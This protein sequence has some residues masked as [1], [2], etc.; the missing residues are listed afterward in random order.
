[1]R[2][3][4]GIPH[5]LPPTLI[6]DRHPP[7][8]PKRGGHPPLF[9]SRGTGASHGL[10]TERSFSGLL[11]GRGYHPSCARR[12]TH[13]LPRSFFGA[14]NPL[15]PCL[16]TGRVGTPPFQRIMPNMKWKNILTISGIMDDC[17]V[18]SLKQLSKKYS[19]LL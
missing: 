4:Q 15:P 6:P 12:G 2:H 9:C 14:G 8:H 11:P 5:P 19:G 7:P 1:M 10:T 13:P 16:G 17:L 3:K 18:G